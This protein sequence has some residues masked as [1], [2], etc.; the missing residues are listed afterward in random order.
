MKRRDFITLLGGAAAWPLVARAQQEA[1]PLIGFLS[2]D[3]SDQDAG[4]MRGFR[5]GL[6]ET[7]YFESRNVAI[8]FRWAEGQFDRLPALAADLVRSRVTVIVANSI[9]VA[10]AAKAATTTIP[11]VFTTVADPVAL[12]LVA[13][14]NRPGGNLTGVI[15]LNVELMQKRLE[16]LHE[17]VP[18]STTFAAL[19]NPTNPIAEP[20]STEAQAAARTLGLQLHV[21]H[22]STESDFDT[23]FATLVQLR[24]GA[25]LIGID[26]FLRSRIEQLAALALRHAIPA[27]WGSRAFPASG[28]LISYGSTLPDI[29]TVGIYT[30]RILKGEKPA[31]LPVQ[32][33]TK[34]EMVLNLKTANARPDSAAIFSAARRRGDRI[35]MQFAA[36]RESGPGPSRHAAFGRNC[37]DSDPTRP[38]GTGSAYRGTPAMCEAVRQRA[39]RVR[40]CALCFVLCALCFVLCALCRVSDA[41]QRQACGIHRRPASESRQGTNPRR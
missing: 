1:L 26:A 15:G 6:S 20:Q 2:I 32:R 17:L 30:G 13:S 7:G 18:R 3:S 31:D 14:L 9:R 19:V 38:A 36:V 10:F 29:R 37:P 40:V 12:G 4:Y 25:L 27:I 39:R 22:A 41:G 11:I 34:F 5:Q 23:V 28:G 35:T 16:L 33:S 8:E 21:L 24:A